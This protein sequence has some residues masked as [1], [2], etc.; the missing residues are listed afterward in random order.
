MPPAPPAQASGRCRLAFILR[1]SMLRGG[2]ASLSG[3]LQ[4]GSETRRVVVNQSCAPLGKHTQGIIEQHIL[5][6][7]QLTRFTV[8]PTGYGMT[9]LVCSRLSYSY[10]LSVDM[11]KWIWTLAL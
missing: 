7:K 6:G 1:T 11:E 2:N 10:L 9:P 5:H 4:R 3:K 8:T